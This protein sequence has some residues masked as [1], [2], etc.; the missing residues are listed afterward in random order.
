[1]ITEM[2]DTQLEN[3]IEI[4]SSLMAKEEIWPEIKEILED[5]MHGLIELLSELAF[6]LRNVNPSASER[7]SYIKDIVSDIR[8]NCEIEYLASASYTAEQKWLERYTA[9]DDVWAIFKEKFFVFKNVF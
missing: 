7:I 4:T 8:M 9:D 3:A 5:N 1:M 2:N 6:Y